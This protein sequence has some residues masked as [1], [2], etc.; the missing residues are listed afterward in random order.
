[1]HPCCSVAVVGVIVTRNEIRE[2]LGQAMQSNEGNQE[3]LRRQERARL[4]H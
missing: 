2:D 4:P 3:A 1:M